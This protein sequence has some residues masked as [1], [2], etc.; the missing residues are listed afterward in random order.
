MRIIDGIQ[1]AFKLLVAQK[2]R[3]A[4]NIIGIMLGTASVVAVICIGDSGGEAILSRFDKMGMDCIAIKSNMRLTEEECDFLTVAA[5]N[6]TVVPVYMNYGRLITGTSERDV[7]IW[8]VTPG[9]E[10]VFGVELENGRYFSKYDVENRRNVT[11]A[12]AALGGSGEFILKTKGK[13]TGIELIGTAEDSGDSFEMLSEAMPLCIYMP[14]TTVMKLFGTS[15][16]DYVSVKPDENVTETGI[17]AVRRLERRFGTFGK[18]YA[19]NMMQ[20][21][22]TVESVLSLIKLI[23]GCIAAVSIAVGTVGIV[24]VMLISVTEKADFIGMLKAIGAKK[25]DILLIFL[26]EAAVLV[27][28]GAFLGSAVGMLIASG[29]SEYCGFSFVLKLKKI[30]GLIFAITA[31]GIIFGVYPAKIAA[32]LD[33]VEALR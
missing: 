12:E 27:L 28:M 10:E 14:Y 5:E 30:L 1:T 25:R 21:K 3:S 6:S 18:Y 32:G 2:L 16:V 9:F 23:L 8:G 17:K 15:R 33:P 11:I 20:H 24:N 13:T 26:A 29:L 31:S 22:E 19:E 4:L 7:I